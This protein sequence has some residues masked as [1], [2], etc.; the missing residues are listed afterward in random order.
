MASNPR[1]ST[2]RGG[3]GP[4]GAQRPLWQLVRG[5]IGALRTKP[6]TSKE[7]RGGG[8]RIEGQ[9]G[10]GGSGIWGT[11]AWRPGPPPAEGLV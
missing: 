2:E 3:R 8:S 9:R 6:E 1:L 11:S 4:V 7:A 5:W 10:S